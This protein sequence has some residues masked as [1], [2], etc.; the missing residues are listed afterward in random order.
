MSLKSRDQRQRYDRWARP[1]SSAGPSCAEHDDPTL[2]PQ[3]RLKY[4]VPDVLD[5]TVKYSHDALPETVGATDPV[6]ECSF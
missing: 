1:G 6:W 2:G 5:K 4:S 3:C